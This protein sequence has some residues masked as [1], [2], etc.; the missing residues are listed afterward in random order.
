MFMKLSSYY[1]AHDPVQNGV[2]IDKF[3]LSCQ[4][5]AKEQSKLKIYKINILLVMKNESGE[6]RESTSTNL[7]M[8]ITM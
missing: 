7:M 2:Q 5:V 1:R 8:T 4:P 3:V 6:Q